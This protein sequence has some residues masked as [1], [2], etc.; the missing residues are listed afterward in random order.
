MGH[1]LALLHNIVGFKVL[2]ILLTVAMGAMVFQLSGPFKAHALN[3][4]IEVKP[5]PPGIVKIIDR[6]GE[7]PSGIVNPEGNGPTAFTTDSDTDS[8]TVFFGE[9]PPEGEGEPP[10]EGEG[11]LPPP[12][13]TTSPPPDKK[14]APKGGRAAPSGTVEPH[15]IGPILTINT[16]IDFGTVFPGETVSG[17]FTIYLTGV[18]TIPWTGTYTSISYNVTMLSKFGYQDMKSSMIVERDPNEAPETEPDSIADGPIGDYTAQGTLDPN[19]ISDTWIVRLE[20][21]DVQGDYW[22]EILIEVP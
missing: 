16:N 22:I 17:N 21:P 11:E 2:A 13:E 9:P 5:T 3:V 14:P 6:S 1:I 19:D 7:P 20:V 8:G 10:P 4:H 12:P 18:D 15:D